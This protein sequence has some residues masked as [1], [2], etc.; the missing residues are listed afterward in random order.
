MNAT[1][2]SF[3]RGRHSQKP[4][5]ILIEVEGFES[6]DKASK[7]AGKKVVW[8]SSAGKKIVGTITGMHGRNGI[9]K[10]RFSKGFPPLGLGKKIKVLG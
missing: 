1:V 2:L 6:K 10:A 5:Q 3:R 7:L 4:N 9:V 8:T